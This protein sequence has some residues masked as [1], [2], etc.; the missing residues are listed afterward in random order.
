[1]GLSHR[2]HIQTS[3]KGLTQTT[4]TDLKQGPHTWA[5]HA[6]LIHGP[7]TQATCTDLKQGPHTWAT[8]T[9]LKKGLAHRPASHMGHTYRP[10]TRASH[11]GLTH[12]LHRHHHPLLL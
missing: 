2:P 11:T 12:R 9:D 4:H 3:N 1:M 6:G 5:T 7:C 10:Q 8:H